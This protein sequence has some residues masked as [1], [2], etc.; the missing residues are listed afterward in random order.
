[1]KLLICDKTDT[2][3]IAAMRGAGITVDEKLGMTPDELAA[4]IPPYEAMVVRSATKV[5]AKV[6]DAASDL[7]L[8][9][10]GGV[11]LDNIDVGYAKTKGITVRNTPLASADSVAELVICYMIALARRIPQATAS[12]CFGKWEK[13]ALQGSEIQGKTLGLIGF[14]NIGQAVGRRAYALGMRVLFYRR[15]PTS[16]DLAEQVD[17]DTLLAESDY[18]SLHVPLTP[19]TANMIDAAAFAKMK[20]GVR[21]INCGRGGTLDEDALYEALKSGKVAGAALDVYADEKVTRGNARLF[22]LCDADGFCQVIGSPHIGASTVEA[23]ARIGQEV[24]QIAIE[25]ATLARR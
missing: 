11:G 3:A 8:I 4:A 2:N 16:S 9:V 21:I 24:A 15:T 18:I 23:Q 12:M 14:G 1:M 7:K 20:D 22:E 25:F 6:I 19:E 5:T 13:K 10:R 17:L